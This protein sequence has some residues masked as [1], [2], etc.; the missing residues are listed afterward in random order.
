M[1]EVFA[2]D[3]RPKFLVFGIPKLVNY[4]RT[5]GFDTIYLRKDYQKAIRIAK[6]EGRI[7]VSQINNLPKLPWILYLTEKK[8][9]LRLKEIF[10]KLHL[11]VNEEDIYTRCGACN[12]P[13]ENLSV[14]DAEKILPFDIK[15]CAYLF[16]R[17]PKCGKIYWK[18]EHYLTLKNKLLKLG[19][20][21]RGKY[22]LFDHTADLG[23]EAE[24]PSL[25]GIFETLGTA[26][27]SE[28]IEGQ[29]EEKNRYT[30]DITSSSPEGLLVRFLNELLYKF[31][32]EELLC[33]SFS[34]ILLDKRILC[35]CF[36]GKFNPRRHI[37]KREI[38][39]ATYHN[40]C[41]KKKQNKW[42]ARVILDI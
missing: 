16:K 5:L 9:D 36:G 14:E 21:E 17:C 1:K 42:V 34:C 32:V 30:I 31:E 22:S 23:I 39:A 24:A 6:E 18:G 13:L 3:T 38:K 37:Q 12:A 29:I 8:N 41:L 26:L 35:N 33:K 20:M 27:F 25:E 15:K 10:Q 7:L 19:I 2:T 11:T 4:L 28:L 40:L